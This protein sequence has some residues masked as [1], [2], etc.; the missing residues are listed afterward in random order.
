MIDTSAF[1]NLVTQP[2]WSPQGDKLSF[3]T[4]NTPGPEGVLSVEEGE[5]WTLDFAVTAS[6]PTFSN[7]QQIVTAPSAGGNVFYP[8]FSPD[9]EWIAYC[10]ASSGESYH[11]EAS[12]I[13]LIKS[14]RSVGPIRLNLANHGPNLYNSWPRWAPTFAQDKY[15]LVFSSEREYGPFIEAGPQQLWVTLIDAS[16]LPNDPSSPAIW[17]PGQFEFSGNLTAEW[18]LSR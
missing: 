7:P 16:V 3:V 9:G 13:W 4:S 1:A 10:S 2:F 6:V 12:E 17:L 8:S 5:I 11:N 14:D 15:W 18:S